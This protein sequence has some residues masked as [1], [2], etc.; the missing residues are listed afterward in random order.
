MNFQFAAEE[1]EALEFALIGPLTAVLIFGIPIYIFWRARTRIFFLLF[2]GGLF[3]IITPIFFQA[4]TAMVFGF[5]FIGLILI[6]VA[7][8]KGYISKFKAG[9]LFAFTVGVGVTILY[10]L[11]RTPEEGKNGMFEGVVEL[12]PSIFGE[13]GALWGGFGGPGFFMLILISIFAIGFVLYQ[14]FE[15][16][17]LFEL[18]DKEE[19]EKSMES[20]ISSTVDKAISEL[21]EGKDIKETIM[22]CYQ[23]MST[24][25]EEEGIKNEDYMTPREFEKVANENLDVATSKI[26]SIREIFELAKYSSH[27][28]EER[29]KER[30]LEDLE[31]LRDELK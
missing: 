28:L 22:R 31:A 15:L 16:Y 5:T 17:H 27:R 13:E 6:S 19:E 14:K 11:M 1:G 4:L 24:I 23:R 2:I 8:K 25:L 21:H 26:S 3:F 12:T 7:F 20:D 29:E 10:L 9:G 30:V 18:S